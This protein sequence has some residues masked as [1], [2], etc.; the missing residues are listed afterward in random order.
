VL[1]LGCASADL[2]PGTE[3]PCSSPLLGEG[4]QKPPGA[5]PEAPREVRLEALPAELAALYCEASASCCQRAGRSLDSVECTLATEAAH[6]EEFAS[7]AAL[8]VR[9]DAAAAARCVQ[10]RKALYSRCDMP[11]G[12]E[13]GDP[14]AEVFAGELPPGAV[15]ESDVEC[16]RIAGA[17]AICEPPQGSA[18]A[19]CQARAALDAE[20]VGDT[21]QTGLYCD[22]FSA[23]CQRR[24]E[25]GECQLITAC[26]ATA[27][28]SPQAQC[29][30]RKAVG[31]AC[32]LALQCE[33]NW[34]SR[35]G[36]CEKPL[37]SADACDG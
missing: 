34:C 35:S 19:V 13:T 15:C 26:A 25:T 33:S 16:A 22:L 10:S 21:C 30:P 1:L 6:L 32:L 4:C 14:C 12:E 7:L 17:P 37:G 2:E 24:K 27:A 28:C 11:S 9:Y 36:F 8:S 5:S 29:E 20:C 3:R 23:S 18:V 31:E